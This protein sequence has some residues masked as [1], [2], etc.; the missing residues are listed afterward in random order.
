MV[1]FVC[2]QCPSPSARVD[3]AT[4]TAKAVKGDTKRSQ[5]AFQIFYPCHDTRAPSFFQKYQQCASECQ[6]T[7]GADLRT[8]HGAKVANCWGGRLCRCVLVFCWSS[9]RHRG[10]LLRVLVALLGRVAAFA[11]P[12]C[13]VPSISLHLTGTR[14]KNRKH[15]WAV[16]GCTLLGQSK[17]PERGR[18]NEVSIY[19]ENPVACDRH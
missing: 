6:V 1:Q 10:V 15:L 12:A 19:N 5:N 4:Q 2:T 18:K 17:L 3:M 9:A 16:Y 14:P 13:V 8:E 7:K 11:V